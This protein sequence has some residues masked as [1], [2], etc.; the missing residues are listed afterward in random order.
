M[1][2]DGRVEGTIEVRDHTLTIGPDARIEADIAAKEVIVLGAVTGSISAGEKIVLGE[3]SVV[4]GDVITPKF[5]MA[6][7]AVLRGR[8]ETT[9]RTAP[10][11]AK[12]QLAVAGARA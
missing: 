9:R 10:S 5:G 1:T 12:G 7:G 11:D 2:I 8:L 3:Q 4:E 6:D